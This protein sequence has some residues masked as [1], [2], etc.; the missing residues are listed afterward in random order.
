MITELNSKK[1]FDIVGHMKIRELKQ[2]CIVRGMPFRQVV[3]STVWE[4]QSFLINN[5]IK[6]TDKT[7]LNDFD[8]WMNT[9]L[10]EEGLEDLIHPRLNMGYFGEDE[11]GNEHRRQIKNIAISNVASKKEIALFKPRKGSKKSLVY[12]LIRQDPDITTEE[13]IDRMQ[14]EFPDCPIGSIKS[15]ASRAR[16]SVRYAQEFE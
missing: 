3:E 1:V 6:P 4:L 7:L 13:L 8:D 5:W 15:W 2:A 12:E 11:E 14:E 9:E 10:R 16:K